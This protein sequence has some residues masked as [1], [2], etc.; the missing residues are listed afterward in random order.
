[1]IQ[2]ED[3]PNRFAIDSKDFKGSIDSTSVSDSK[4][5]PVVQEQTV[6]ASGVIFKVQQLAAVRPL[7]TGKYFAGQNVGK[8][9]SEMHEGLYK[10]TTG[11]YKYYKDARAAI[12]DLF[13]STG[14]QE[15][16]V[17]AYNNGNRITVKEA[18]RLTRQKWFK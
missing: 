2:V 18:L 5:K 10:Y 1:M 15:A 17:T 16:F 7:H 4:N 11:N 14:I 13:L 3:K 8:I 6:V 12:E 9:S